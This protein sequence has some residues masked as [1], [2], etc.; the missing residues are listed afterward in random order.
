MRLFYSAKKEPDLRTFD[1]GFY[2]LKSLTGEVVRLHAVVKMNQFYI[3]FLD[4]SIHSTSIREN[5]L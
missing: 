4:F 5:V 2:K 3:D 1:L